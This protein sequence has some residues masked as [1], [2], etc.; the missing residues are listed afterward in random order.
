M[1]NHILRENNYLTTSTKRIVRTAI[2]PYKIEKFDFESQVLGLLQN[3]RGNPN[4]A[5]S[6]EG[7]TL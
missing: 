4:V 5:A 1:Q 2:E 3:Q 7:N 6:T